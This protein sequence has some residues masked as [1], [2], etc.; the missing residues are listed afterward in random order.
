[1][2]HGSDEGENYWPGY[3]DALTSMVQVLA[4]VMM[5][6]SMAIYVLSQNAAKNAI[7]AIAKA[8]NVSMPKNATVGELTDAIIEKIRSRAAQAAMR[9]GSATTPSSGASGAAPAG[10]K[11]AA[12]ANAAADKPT[13]ASQ[14]A[15]TLTPANRLVAAI[16]FDPQAQPSILGDKRLSVHFQNRSYELVASE[17]VNID[18]FLEKQKTANKEVSLGV[19]AYA[20]SGAGRLTEE[21]RVAYYRALVVRAALIERK[22]SADRLRVNVL[23]TL[24]P[25]QGLTVDIFV[26]EPGVN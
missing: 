26:I 1:M 21:R 12:L 16:P 9:E 15:R 22:A 13:A 2:S 24:D 23:D 11:G 10:N 5:L 8:E 17:S 7:S 25:E 4:F 18:A 14:S 3:V 19:R 20:Y 6:L